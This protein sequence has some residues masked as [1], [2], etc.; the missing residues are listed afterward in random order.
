VIRTNGANATLR[1]WAGASRPTI[2]WSLFAFYTAVVIVQSIHVVE[3]VIQLVQ[4]YLLGIADD[5]ALGL[6]GYVFEFQGTEE[7]LHL[8]FNALY[9]TGL[10]LIAV[11]LLRS[12]AA[13]AAIPAW[14]FAMLLFFGVWLEAWH[15]IE[16]AV[17]IANVVSNDGCPCPGILDARLGVSDT[18]LHFI[19]NLIAYIA[20]ALP[21]LFLFLIHPRQRAATGEVS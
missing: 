1:S 4:V 11:G 2:G 15:V 16:H 17:I 19:Y 13:R 8:V 6:L 5:D 18:I 20:T 10:S 3:H 9:L 7:W 14:V 12:P 21:F